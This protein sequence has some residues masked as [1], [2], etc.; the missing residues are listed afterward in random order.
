MGHWQ[1]PIRGG[2]IFRPGK[3][4]EGLR[5]GVHGY[6]AQAN[7]KIDAAKAEKDPCRM[8]TSTLSIKLLHVARNRHPGEG[9][10]PVLLTN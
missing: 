9:R 10:G 4:I 3:E 5:G 2:G 6:A 8:E 7:P 1:F